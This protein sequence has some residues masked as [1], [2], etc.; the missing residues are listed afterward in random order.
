MSREQKIV[1]I[2]GPNGAGKTTFAREFL[3]NEAGCP[4]FVNVDLI[5][6]GLS[7]FRPEAAAIRAGRIMLE[8]IQVHVK[9]RESFAFETT[10]SGLGYARMIPQWR[11]KGYRVKL[12]FLRLPTVKMAIARVRLRVRQGGHS[13]AES[14]IRRRFK[15]G[16]RNFETVYRDLVDEWVVYDNSGDEPILV[17]EGT[18][19]AQAKR[20]VRK[21]RSRHR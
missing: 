21:P 13:V 8:Q 6:M 20:S 17:S 15:T 5:A 4:V 16:W 10:L 2:A 1:I 18:K 9:K 11:A 19:G 3:P 14:V 7:P 12:I